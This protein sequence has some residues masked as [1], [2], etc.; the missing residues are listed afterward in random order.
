[1]TENKSEQSSTET[2]DRM[3]KRRSRFDVNFR[4]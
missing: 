3:V 1:M 4:V 2:S